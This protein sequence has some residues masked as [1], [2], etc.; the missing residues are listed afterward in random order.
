MPDGVVYATRNEIIPVTSEIIRI[1]LYYV[2]ETPEGRWYYCEEP[3]DLPKGDA[4]IEQV[5]M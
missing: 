5:K 4:R 1:S 2:R 3:L